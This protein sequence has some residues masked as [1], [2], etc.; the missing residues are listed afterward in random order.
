MAA[1]S[2]MMAA[3][4]V[5]TAVGMMNTV[6]IMAEETMTDEE[7]AASF[8]RRDSDIDGQFGT[9][10]WGSADLV[11]PSGSGLWQII[12]VTSAAKDGN[13]TAV[14]AF[15]SWLERNGLTTET[16]IDESADDPIYPFTIDEEKQADLAAYVALKARTDVY[17]NVLDPSVAPCTHLTDG[18]YVIADWGSFSNPERT[19]KVRLVNIS[20]DTRARITSMFVAKTETE[21]VLVV[22]SSTAAWKLDAGNTSLLGT[23]WKFFRLY[24]T[25]DNGAMVI[26]PDYKSAIISALDLP[27]SSSETVV[28]NA[29]NELRKNQFEADEFA[30]RLRELLPSEATYDV[31]VTKV[32]GQGNAII[33]GMEPGW[34]MGFAA[35]SGAIL[36][37]AEEGTNDDPTVIN[38]KAGLTPT[39]VKKIQEDDGAIGWNDIA[40]LSYGD[41]IHYKYETALPGITYVSNGQKNMFTI[42]GKEQEF[43]LTFEDTVDKGIKSN[44]ENIVIKID[45][46]TVPSEYIEK[47]STANGFNLKLKNIS[48]LLQTLYPD[49][50]TI[51]GGQ[52]VTVEYQHWFYGSGLTD[53]MGKNSEYLNT[54]SMKY[55]THKQ[56]SDAEEETPEDTVALYTYAVEVSKQAGVNEQDVSDVFLP[57]AE[58]TI[59]TGEYN[60]DFAKDTR[61]EMKVVKVDGGY[62]AGGDMTNGSTVKTDENGKIVIQGLDSGTYTLIETKA[63]DGYKLDATPIIFTIEPAYK[64]DRGEELEDGGY[65]AGDFTAKDAKNLTKVSGKVRQGE[66]EKNISTNTNLDVQFSVLNTPINPGDLP[67]TG[68]NWTLILTAAGGLLVVAGMI[69]KK[70]RES[71]ETDN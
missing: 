46:Q 50:A 67:A 20:N 26:N 4:T 29:L 18:I 5:G 12:S 38:V 33:K 55:P 7:W 68:S 47:A 10:W 6:P 54:V 37:L 1:M 13:M 59:Y 27:T 58:F 36:H 2:G 41:Y 14:D 19:P 24:T 22:D 49:E 34:Y 63:P 30:N 35:S 9:D 71:E 61:E 64:T 32:D 11:L 17:S 62:I 60:A 21:S 28:A 65:A 3:G 42:N 51:V 69:A 15:Q 66:S 53:R 56:G 43:Y 8:K 57:G 44:A 16:L 48:S 52:S 45:G 25:D 31:P 39:V 40:D 70:K 23:E